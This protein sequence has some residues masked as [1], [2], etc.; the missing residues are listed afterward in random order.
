MNA[1]PNEQY[2]L[3][4]NKC[5]SC[6]ERNKGC[7]IKRISFHVASVICVLKNKNNKNYE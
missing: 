7:K 4:Q 1:F 5:P 6:G 3:V 2:N